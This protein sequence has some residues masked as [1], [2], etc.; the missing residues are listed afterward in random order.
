VSFRKGL[1]SVVIAL[2]SAKPQD[3]SGAVRERIAMIRLTQAIVAVMGC[4]LA[5]GL[6]GGVVGL[7][8]GTFAPA[9]VLWIEDLP[10]G[11]PPFDPVEFGL[12]L[13]VVSGLF[14]GAAVG[15]FLVAVIALRDAWLARA[16]LTPEGVRAAREEA[17]SAF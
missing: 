14:F 17:A 9:L 6:A 1:A 8:L 13:G 16:G 7:A 12:G 15:S 4:T 5:A 2:Y 10:K 11:N 3:D